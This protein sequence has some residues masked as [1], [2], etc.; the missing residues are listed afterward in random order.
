MFAAAAAVSALLAALL[1]Y[2]A[3]R[4]L[5]HSDDVVRSYARAGVPEHRLD[6]LAAILF[7]GAAGLLVGLWWEPL[8]VASAAGLVAYFVV[9]CGFHIRARDTR[10]LPTPVTL[11]VLAVASLLLRL[12]SG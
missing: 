1:V 12:A 7:A 2:S 9:A 5:T 11:A 6:T 8:G 10:N 3:A 4:K